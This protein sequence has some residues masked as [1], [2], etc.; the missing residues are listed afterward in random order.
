MLH[1]W[2]PWLLAGAILVGCGCWGCGS[3]PAGEGDGPEATEAESAAEATAPVELVIL[4]G[5]SFRPPMEKLVKMYEDET[6]GKA[7]LVFGGS[8]DHLPKVKMKAIGDVFVTHTPYMQYTRDA[9]ALLR[10]VG[11]GHLAPVL[12]VQKGN[13]KDIRKIEDLAREGVRVVLPNPDYSTCGEMVFALLD[14]KE[15]KE[16]VLENVGNAQ[17]R[18]HAE[19]ASPIKLDHRDAGIMW[20][21][22]AH[23][24]L[25]ALEIVAT[26]Y[27]YD[28]EIRVAVM[29]LSYTEHE[30]AVEKLLD[31]VEQH[32]PEVFAEFGYV[33][34]VASPE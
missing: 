26:P 33:K 9:G 27:E 4:C 21:G 14:K 2:R 1:R 15:I 19:V 31:F 8:E 6:G 28:E 7:V 3:Q 22:V 18:Q 5:S 13:P 11:V 25:D 34:S 32:G 16:A 12:V 23:N 20:N 10:E 24:W 30:E 17:V 29:G